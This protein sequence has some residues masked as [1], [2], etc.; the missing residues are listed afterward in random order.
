MSARGD[1]AIIV[2]V[3]P[4]SP[5]CCLKQE[6]Y[7]S[8]ILLYRLL[9]LRSS[10]VLTSRLQVLVPTGIY[11]PEPTYAPAASKNSLYIDRWTDVVSGLCARVA[12]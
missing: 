3:R 11:V 2:H 12:L 6:G 8:P 7:Y 10:T 5:V 4:I 1:E 9:G